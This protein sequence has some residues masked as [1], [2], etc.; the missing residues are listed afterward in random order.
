MKDASSKGLLRQPTGEQSVNSKLS[1]SQV[2]E[3]RRRYEEG[4]AR[5]IEL[6]EEFGIS[7]SQV[8]NILSRS[9]WKDV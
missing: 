1:K 4:G 5:S 9:Q 8:W 3:I 2:A 7:K 6:A